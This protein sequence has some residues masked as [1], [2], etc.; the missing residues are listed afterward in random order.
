MKDQ[1]EI[2]KSKKPGKFLQDNAKLEDVTLGLN[3]E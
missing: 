2:M 3:K 1:N